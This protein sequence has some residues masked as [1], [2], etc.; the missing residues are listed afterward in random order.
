MSLHLLNSIFSELKYCTAY[1]SRDGITVVTP[2]NMHI[3][4]VT[5]Y[6]DEPLVLA[7]LESITAA[8]RE[9]VDSAGA[10]VKVI[11][12]PAAAG[13]QFDFKEEKPKDVLIGKVV[14]LEQPGWVKAKKPSEAKPV[15]V[16]PEG[17]VAVAKRGRA[18]KG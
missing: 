6:Y 14:N 12:T 1:S 13:I 16:E 9:R 2:G 3:E 4:V 15:T 5:R 7:A 18:K 11:E 10:P 8:L 17:P